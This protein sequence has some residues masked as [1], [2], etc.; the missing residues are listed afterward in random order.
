M[1]IATQ[2]DLNHL[3][4]VK[5]SPVKPKEIYTFPLKGEKIDVELLSED[6]LPFIF[7]LYK[8]ERSI[9]KC[10]YL[11]RHEIY[12]LIRLDLGDVKHKN[13]DG[14]IITGSHLHIYH[15]DCKDKTA[16]ALPTK[17]FSGGNNFKVILN[18]FMTFSKITPLPLFQYTVE[19][20]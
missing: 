11:T 7:H 5:K 1:R 4:Y 3:L 16:I 17:H 12:P 8:G 6:K 13:P 2:A 15:L 19:D 20:F 10:S 18:E 14:E 9:I